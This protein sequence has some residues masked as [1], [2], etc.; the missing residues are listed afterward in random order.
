MLRFSPAD[1]ASA[2]ASTAMP[3][4]G[5]ILL[6]P[7]P[8]LMK[9]APFK[10]ICERY[11]AAMIHP[12]THLYTTAVAPAD[13][14][15]KAYRIDEVLPYSSGNITRIARSKLNADVAVR[16]FPISADAL[17]SRLGIKKSGDTRIAGITAC[18]GNQYLLFLSATV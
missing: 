4:K 12:N 14:P 18:D 10:L 2:T 5:Q 8:A 11:D 16:N 15:G 1:E 6:E 7:S 17:R 3:A 13:F 9:A